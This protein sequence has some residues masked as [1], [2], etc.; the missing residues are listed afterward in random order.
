MM[1]LTDYWYDMIVQKLGLLHVAK[2]SVNET[3]PNKKAGYCQ[4]NV[5]QR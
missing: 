1:G 2:Q 5:R 3:M 4:Q